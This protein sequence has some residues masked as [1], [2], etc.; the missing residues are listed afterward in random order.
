MK[1]MTKKALIL[2]KGRPSKYTKELA[3]RICDLI[4]THPNGLVSLCKMYP[5]LPSP[6]I[7]RKWLRDSEKQDFLHHYKISLYMRA[8]NFFDEI[9]EIADTPQIGET[10]TLKAGE[11][12]IT[13]ADMIQ[14]RRLRIDVRKW[15]VSKLL[16]KKYGDTAQ[17]QTGEESEP[18]QPPKIEVVIS[19]DVVDKV[20]R[21]R[22]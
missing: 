6:S 17:M 13:Q 20:N 10:I 18:Y 4:A 5:D 12:E 22:N 7:I 3:D 9:I 2:S 19:Q 1:D 16:P 14:H 15:I 21:C 11:R 8:D